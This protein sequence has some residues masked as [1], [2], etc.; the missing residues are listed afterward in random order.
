MAL[1]LDN[2]AIAA[3]Q[4]GILYVLVAVGFICD[5]V[6]LF[7]E[8][9]ARMS[10]DLLFYVITPAVI[11]TSF[12]SV[13]NTKDNF[14]KLLMAAGFGVV[15]QIVGAVLVI[16]FFRDK[17]K[18]DNCIFKFA[19]NYG[20]V[21]YMA[22]PL[23]KAVLGDE[24]V[25]YCS[26]VVMVFNIF[27]FTHGIK[28]M[29]SSSKFDLKKLI[30]NPGTIAVLIGLPLFILGVKLP[31]II[32]TPVDYIASLNTPLAMLFFGTYLSQTDLK[33]MFKD[34]RVYLVAFLKLIAMPLCMIGIFKLFG[35]TGVMV[36]A[37]LIS[38]SAPSANNTVMF[39]AKYD[40]NAPTASKV[41]ALVSFMSIITMPVMIALGQQVC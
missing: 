6:G 37:I 27:S 23:A 12:L 24:G 4:V 13:D 9:T 32:Q 7:K 18:E 31:E 40:K 14:I 8:K 22:L 36:S 30:I 16:P 28:V 25:F 33:T 2:L 19:S 26:A 41:V 38:S 3:K 34:K 35:I 11:I 29:T 17:K 20:N 1:F 10:N 5:K 21:G 39:A 15:L